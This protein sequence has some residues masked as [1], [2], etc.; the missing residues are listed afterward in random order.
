MMT[1]QA[2]VGLVMLSFASSAGCASVVAGGEGQ[3]TS[4]AGGGDSGTTATGGEGQATSGEGSG[5]NPD[6]RA[7]ASC[8]LTGSDH[9][10]VLVDR[11]PNLDDPPVLAQID[12]VFEPLPDGFHVVGAAGTVK[13]FGTIPA[14]PN[15]TFVHMD[16][17]YNEGSESPR[18]DLVV[19]KNL[20]TLGG[21][22]NPTEGG[23]RL[24]FAGGSGGVDA[25]S[26]ILPFNP[27]FE[28]ACTYWSP[29]PPSDID[30]S[31]DVTVKTLDLTGPGFSVAIA[32]GQG[33]TFTADS[34]P[35]AGS[36]H[37]WND[38][39]SD[40]LQRGYMTPYFVLYLRIDRAN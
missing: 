39:I 4:G 2:F 23:E 1:W 34:G 24:W 5:M 18:G 11:S 27:S 31:A 22:P 15:G 38:D 35:D 28:A 40:V 6:P 32:P 21:K 30:L 13:S 3:E 9:G 29:S 14:I 20:A 37:V 36:Y 33:G 7:G 8:G 26:G 25:S 17:A 10:T 16:Y 12:G 19:I